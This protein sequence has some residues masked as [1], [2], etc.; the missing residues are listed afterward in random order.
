M[1]TAEL[2]DQPGI[3]VYA[4]IYIKHVR[5]RG[6]AKS[7]YSFVQKWQPSTKDKRAAQKFDR[8][9]RDSKLIIRKGR[10][11][12]EWNHDSRIILMSEIVRVLN[13]F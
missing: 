10:Q 6:Y 8:Y 2:I 12:Y 1:T 4:V 5:Q 3:C 9:L 11:H 7:F 13:S